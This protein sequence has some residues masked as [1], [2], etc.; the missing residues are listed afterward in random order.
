MKCHHFSE[1]LNRFL[2]KLSRNGRASFCWSLSFCSSVLSVSNQFVRVKQDT[3]NRWSTTCKW[4]SAY[5]EK[6]FP[7]SRFSTYF[8][9]FSS[10]CPL[11][12][13][14]NCCAALGKFA[15]PIAYLEVI[16][17]KSVNK[18]MSYHN[19][20]SLTPLMSAYFFLSWL[21]TKKSAIPSKMLIFLFVE[22]P[23]LNH[24]VA[25]AFGISFSCWI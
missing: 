8:P 23:W 25:P 4:S 12:N 10:T 9:R 21:L 15:N 20:T 14:K 6:V 22:L 13:S 3:S 11:G 2:Q 24:P 18:I 1:R 17:K 19:S 7:V 16:S 5:G